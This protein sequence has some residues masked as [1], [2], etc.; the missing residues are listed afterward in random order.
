MKKGLKI[1]GIVLL[2]F[3]ALL[4]ILPFAF[5]GKIKDIAIDQ[6]N[7]NLNAEI[8]MGDLSL[9]FFKNFPNAS[10][11]IENFGVVGKNEFKGD[12]LANVGKLIAVVNI[13]SF[14]GNSYEINEIGLEDA[15]VYAKVLENG[16]ANWDITIPD[17]TTKE[18]VDTSASSPI[19]LNLESFL[20]K[21]MNVVFND[22]QA[23]MYASVKDLNLDLAGQFSNGASLA[24]VENMKLGVAKIVY[25]DRASAMGASLDQFNFTFSGS[26]SDAIA[27][28]KTKI[29]VDKVSFFMS[30]IPYLSN[31]KLAADINLDA[32]MKNNKFTFTENSIALNAIKANFS[33]FVQLIDSTTTDMDVQLN[34]PSIDF[35]QILSLIPAIYAKDFESIK[36][37]GK[38]TL[39]AMANGRMQGEK[40]PAFDVK[41]KIADAMFKYPT[42]PSDVKDINIDVEASNPGGI[43]DLTVLN[44]PTLKFNMAGNAFGAHLLLKTPVSDPDFDFGANGT[45]DFNK[46]KDVVP[47]DSMQMT[48]I[49]KADLN[50]QGRLS[51]VEKEMYDKFTVDGNLNLANMIL[52]MASLP[53]DVNVSAANLNFTTAYVDLTEMKIALGKN[54]LDIKGK[55]ENFIPYVMKDETIKGNLSVNSNYFNLNDFISND[56][57]ATEVATAEDTSAMSVVEIPANINFGLNVNFK[58]LIYDNIELE[59]AVGKVTVKDQI[60][61]ISQ[62]STN[63]MGG[64]LNVKGQYNVQN[65]ASPKVNMD[66]VVKNMVISKV[67][68]LVETAK[69]FAPMLADAGGNFS[70]SMNFVSDLGK[71]MM[72]VLKSVVGDGSFSSNEVQINGVKALNMIADKLNN[73]SLKD[74]KIKNLNIGF[75]IKDGR[76]L[77]NPFKTA[78]GNANMEVSGSSGLDQSLDYV[79]AIAVPTSLSSK[80][81]VKANVKIGGTFTSPKIGLDLSSTTDAV[82]EVVKEKVTAVVDKAAQAALEKAL[83]TQKK[84]MAEA[85]SNAEKIRTEAKNAGDKLVAEAQSNADAMVNKAKNPLEKAAK[86]KAGEALVKEAKKQADKI[87]AEADQKANSMVASTQQ[88]TDKLVNDAKAKV[89]ASKK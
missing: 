25:T 32:D 66:F 70:M 37:D 68:S 23:K 59:N 31:A 80:V 81:P 42:L 61:D 52:K 73:S 24:N 51:Y 58:Q 8:F 7:K 57:T 85:T 26:V 53:Y 3:L 29:D 49:L 84:L 67:F 2:V 4:F 88:S 35:K 13:K 56:T 76:L 89:E 87:N 1:A 36:T 10:V 41:L 20:V 30:K 78:V 34:T 18:K 62:L 75:Q 46:L 44:I 48:G 27:K 47:M 39:T 19:N 86:K 63:T 77:T 43:A 38:V 79:A 6:A 71:D 17:T 22:M 65:V 72:P 45:I 14:F 60:L 64:S 28:L 54:D 69:E 21:N 33:G 82:K 5:Q 11:T 74:P 40:L 55:V 12:T 15:Y 83:D 50:A 16:K 9:S